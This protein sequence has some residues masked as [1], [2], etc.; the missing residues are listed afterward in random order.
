MVPACCQPFEEVMSLNTIWLDTGISGLCDFQ[1]GEKVENSLLP[2]AGTLD[3][4]FLRAG[5]A[6]QSEA[7]FSVLWLH[8]WV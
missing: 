4:C 6:G 3:L 8:S 5:R 1:T 7:G 2:R